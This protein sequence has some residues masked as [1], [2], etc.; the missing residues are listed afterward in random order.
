[1]DNHEL[2]AL[3]KRLDRLE[4]KN[5]LL[6]WALLGLLV[7]GALTFILSAAAPSDVQ[8]VVRAKSFEV[9][10]VDGGK[11][12]GI[13]TLS[14]GSTGLSFYDASGNERIALGVL[15]DGRRGSLSTILV[16][17]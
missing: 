4:A 7:I 10:D 11:R 8:D 9:I 6:S 5:R 2:L 14:D 13:S 17:C 3:Q 16:R 15:S 12:A 1:M